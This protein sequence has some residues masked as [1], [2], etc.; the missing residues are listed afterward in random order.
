MS[1]NLISASLPAADAAEIKQLLTSI[2]TKMPFLVNI[3][4]DEVLSFPKVGNSLKPFI[5]LACETVKTHPEILPGVFDKEEF[6]RDNDLFNTLRPLQTI[7]SEL[8]EALNKTTMAAGSDSMVAALEVYAAV[9][10]HK[11]KVPGLAVIADQMADFFVKTK[12]KTSST[13]K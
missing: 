10:Q 13:A 6:I 3:Q 11:D 9:K 7:I 5:D 2:Q 1:Q 4:S 12:A 8:S